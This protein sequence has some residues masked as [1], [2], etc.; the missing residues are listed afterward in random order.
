M[1]FRVR[2]FFTFSE[3]GGGEFASEMFFEELVAFDFVLE[4]GSVYFEGFEQFV[5]VLI[6]VFFLDDFFIVERR[7]V[8]TLEAA[9]HGEEETVS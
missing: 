7:T 8:G 9:H 1:I 3:I 6:D 5:K 4:L 2:F